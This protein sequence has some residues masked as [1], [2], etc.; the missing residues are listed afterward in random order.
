VKP[1][2][3]VH[4]PLV[5]DDVGPGGE[6][7]AE[8]ADG[9]RLEAALAREG[10]L[11][12]ERIGGR[13]QLGLA[14]PLDRA[15]RRQDRRLAPRERRAV[16]EV[17][18]RRL[19]RVEPEGRPL[20]LPRVDPEHLPVPHLDAVE[21]ERGELGELLPERGRL[22]QLLPRGARPRV[23]R[24]LPLLA[25]RV[26]GLRRPPRTLRVAHLDEVELRAVE[27]DVP[28]ERAVEELAP[29]EA[30]PDRARLEERQE[31]S[32]RA[33]LLDPEAD[34]LVGQVDEAHPHAREAGVH[35]LEPR[36]HPP[37]APGR[38]GIGPES[39][40]ERQREDRGER[41]GEDPERAR[42]GSRPRR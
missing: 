12:R 39:H 31:R 7:R 14:A 20:G 38:E 36:E 26:A 15:P 28:D 21:P 23:P 16:R 42:H 24:L 8:L 40:P 41:E 10:E 37:R 18:E 29:G 25:A 2:R 34:D 11:L 22:L 13:E 19:D 1:H 17:L 30:E 27:I 32:R 6:E 35:A 3:H 33:P 5:G 9:E 4:A